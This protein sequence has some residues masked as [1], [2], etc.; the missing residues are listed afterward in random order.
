MKTLK[1]M[2]PE[3][4]TQLHLNNSGEEALDAANKITR[5]ITI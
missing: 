2:A 1:A 5:K 3:R 4:I